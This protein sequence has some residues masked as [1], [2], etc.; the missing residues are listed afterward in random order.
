MT[1]DG[2]DPEG[3]ALIAVQRAL[4]ADAHLEHD[5]PTRWYL[6]RSAVWAG[7]RAAAERACA[8]GRA[9]FPERGGF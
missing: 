4:Q 2:T 1:D 5:R 6:L 9:D 7:D 8:E 3:G